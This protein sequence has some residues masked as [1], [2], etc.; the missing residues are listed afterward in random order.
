MDVERRRAIGNAEQRRLRRADHDRAQPLD[1]PHRTEPCRLERG[2]ERVAARLGA[3]EKAERHRGALDR[4]RH[5]VGEPQPC[6]AED[7]FGQGDVEHHQ[8]FGRRQEGSAL[9]HPGRGGQAAQ[10]HVLGE[11]RQS[12][13]R[14]LDMRRIA[15]HECAGAMAVDEHA[16]VDQRGDG[17]PERGARDV[18][19][20]GELALA[21]QEVGL[22][23]APGGDLALQR[24]A[25]AGEQRRAFGP[26][27]PKLRH[28]LRL[29]VP[30]EPLDKRYT[31]GP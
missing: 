26:A 25:D 31:C 10:P 2:I 9:D 13:Q 20:L 4:H 6:E 28:F 21:R 22:R 7:G 1:R 5:A 12:R 27:R 18:E 24:G 17:A 3:A 15:P 29:R 23:E 19:H 14:L 30:R 11:T 16:L 8:F